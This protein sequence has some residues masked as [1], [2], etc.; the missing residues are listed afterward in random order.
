MGFPALL[1]LLHCTC[2]GV[3]GSGNKGIWPHGA[4]HWVLHS[5][6]GS[7]PFSVDFLNRSFVR[8]PKFP[9]WRVTQLNEVTLPPRQALLLALFSFQGDV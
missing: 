7:D 4:L 2:C 3:L 9:H 1:P 5:V 6:V 8:L